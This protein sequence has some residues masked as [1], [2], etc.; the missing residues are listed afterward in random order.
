[1]KQIPSCFETTPIVYAVG[2]NYQ[3]MIPVLKETLMW[4][5]VGGKCYY[6]D[7][8]GILR[9]NC[10]THRITIPM[11][12]LNQAKEYKICY[13][14][15]KERKPYF[16]E[17]EEVAEFV[18]SFY[19]VKNEENVRFYHIADTHNMVEKPV[20]SAKAFGKIDF[21]ILNGDL[22]NHSGDIANFTTIHRIASEITGGEIP[23]VFSRGNH[24]MRGVYAE[25][26]AEHTPTD[27]GN[28][29]YTFRLGNVWGMVLD[30]GEDKVD[31]HPEYAH[32]ICCTD[33]RERQT[34]FMKNVI[35]CASEEYAAEDIRI[36]MVISHVPFTEHFEEPFNIEEEIYAEWTRLLR[37]EIH[38]QVMLCG[39]I[40]RA[41][42]S[43]IGGEKDYFGQPCPVV[44][45]AAPGTSAEGADWISTKGIYIGT[46]FEADS[47]ECKISFV[48]SDSN[49]YHDAH[50]SCK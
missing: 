28:S 6:D 37:E 40:H 44:V 50:I 25:N 17:V 1:M 43:P 38:P 36:R 20:A 49:C 5:E 24:D 35:R 16:S 4:A 39:H 34:A 19:P 15:V 45:G 41:Y 9:S 33:F 22:P 14:V 32:T 13:R 29:Y 7:V 2:K 10:T 18:S 42:I 27:H 8:N 26:I 3:I 23:V 47:S 12:A 30:C 31:E 21:L 48:G 11:E 46:G